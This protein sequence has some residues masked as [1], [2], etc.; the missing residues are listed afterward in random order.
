M[1]ADQGVRLGD[2]IFK[3]CVRS[4]MRRVLI[5]VESGS[6]DILK[7]IKKDT[8]IEQIVES[9]E[10][11]V[12]HGVAVIFSFIVGFPG[13]TYDDVMKTVAL[14]KKLRAMSPKF[15]TPIFYYKPYPGSAISSELTSA[16]PAS[17]DEW[18]AFDFVQGEAGQW[19]GP[20]TFQFMERF[21]FYNRYAWGRESLAKRPLQLLARWRCQR[22]WY[23]WPFE[24][25]IVQRLRPELE[26]S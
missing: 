16:M 8:T 3:L 7:R 23:D 25:A 26:L 11:C 10:M 13:E 5:G 15:E 19:V 24:K 22:N 1:R 4:G 6:P 20:E 18:A 2:D 9:A 17:L 12:R 14:I 21:K